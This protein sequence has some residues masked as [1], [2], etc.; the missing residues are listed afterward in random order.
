[1]TTTHAAWLEERDSLL[2]FARELRH[3]YTQS[4]VREKLGLL[5]KQCELRAVRAVGPA[6]R[7]W[8]LDTV[9]QRVQ[10]VRCERL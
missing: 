8:A 9:V 10:Q 4:L 5:S 1:M 2:Y 6:F 3:R 7:R